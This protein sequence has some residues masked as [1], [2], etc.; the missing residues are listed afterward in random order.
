[1]GDKRAVKVKQVSTTIRFSKKEITFRDN[2]P[3][4]AII[5]KGGMTRGDPGQPALPW[6][7]FYLSV[8]WNASIGKLTIQEVQTASLAKKIT[9]EPCQPNVPTMIGSKVEWV[10]PDHKLY[11]SQ[12][13]FPEVFARATVVRRMGGFGLVE[14]EVCPFRYHLPSGDLELITRLKLSLTYKEKGSIPD[15]PRTTMGAVHE[16]KFMQRVED[17]VLNPRDV[18]RYRQFDGWEPPLDWVLYPQIDYVIV[19]NDALLDEFQR[20]AAWRSLFG[21]RSRVVTIEQIMSATV[22]DTGGAVFFHTSG[23]YDGG[24][25][26]VAEAVRNFVKWASVH[27]LIDYVLLGG[28]TEIIPARSAIHSWTGGVY[29]G[30]LSAS[31]TSTQLGFSPI[32]SSEN[33]GALAVNILDD[34][35]TTMWECDPTDA[36]PWIRVGIGSHKPVNRIDLAWGANHATAYSIQVSHD[37]VT[38]TDVY[39]TSSGSGGT[40]E[41]SFACCTAAYVRLRITSGPDFSLAA[42]QVYGPYKGKAY[43]MSGTLTRI[44]LY[45][46]VFPNPTNSVDDDLILIMDGPHAG[47]IIPY[48]ETANSTTLGW[49]FVEDLIEVPG[50]VSP[51]YTGY[52]EIRGPAQF[53]GNAFCLKHDRN[54]IPTD[55]YYADIAASEYPPSTHHD[56]DV[57]DNLIYGERYGGELDGVNGLA[58]LYV[59][60]V[61]VEEPGEASSIIDKIIRYEMF[62]NVD[63]YGFQFLLPMD[64]GVSVLLASQNW[65]STDIPDQLDGSAVGKENIRQVFNTFDPGR[66]IFTRRYQDYSDVPLADQTADLGLASKTEILAALQ[67]GNNVLSLSSHGSSGYLCY[68]V[69]DDIDDIVSPPGIL[70]G[71]ACSTNKFD[72]DPGEALSE[73]ALLNPHGSAVA[74]VGNTRY[75]WTGD[76]PIELVFWETMLTEER[77]GAMFGACKMV[78]HDWAKYSLNLLGDPAMRVWSD[79]PAQI[80]VSHPSEICSGSQTFTVTVTSS[81][82]PVEGA[83]VCVTMEGTVFETSLT[84]AAGI[85]SLTVAP[86][87]AGEMRVTASGK[88]LIPYLGTVTVE[89]CDDVCV[90]E[91]LCG[92]GVFCGLQVSCGVH[93]TCMHVLRCSALIECRELIS[94]ARAILCTRQ[95]FHCLNLEACARAIDICPQILPEE[96][97]VFDQ[98]RDIW[99]I[100]DV[101]ELIGRS[102][103]PEIKETVERLPPEV[104]KSIQMMLERMRAEDMLD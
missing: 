27:W 62:E 102:E 20:L 16:W 63:D 84:N 46:S 85:A 74:Y 41:A 58:D 28:D 51:N 97:Q 50:N 9:V 60:R 91:V 94:C 93:I 71:N 6:R 29:Y 35:E 44:Y 13:N 11:A 61:S 81:G 7:K 26:D 88:N 25:R 65:G 54:Y 2:G 48:D 21:L 100:R 32:A 83:L 15:K 64:F 59:G 12:A 3:Y 5:L 33:A 56:W 36:D 82:S 99:G 55:L 104:R 37:G 90:H 80:N 78:S 24:T 23:Y 47:M 98:I 101:R 72:V 89:E 40:E 86:L 49:R 53:H 79:R 30:D 34:D 8:P 4:K 31:R 87:M 52:V 68:L 92:N 10:P 70:Y 69:T 57:D 96:F 76:N 45:Y 18:A 22:P 75:G 77:L 17:I 67:D 43:S 42:L 66:W 19:T 1:M 95:I 38:W 39:S 103:E 14:I 73:W